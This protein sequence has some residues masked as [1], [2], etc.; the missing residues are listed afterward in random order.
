MYGDATLGQEE[1]KQCIENFCY[2][3]VMKAMSGDEGAARKTPM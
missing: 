1:A 3:F 2:E